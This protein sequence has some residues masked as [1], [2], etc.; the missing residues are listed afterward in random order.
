[1]RFGQYLRHL[2]G[3]LKVLRPSKN[4]RLVFRHVVM[5]S[6]YTACIGIA[7]YAPNTY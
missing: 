4:V 3:P 6:V 1:M 7:R 2:Q 5:M